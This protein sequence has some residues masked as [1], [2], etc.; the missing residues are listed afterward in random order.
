MIHL[1]RVWN[2][3]AARIRRAGQIALLFDFD[4][5]L[6][7][8]ASRPDLPR[9][10]SSNRKMLQ[11][12]AQTNRVAVGVVSGRGLRDLRGRVQL[13]GIYYAGNHGLELEGPR[14]RFLH[15]GAAAARADL[16]RI[17]RELRRRLKGVSG[18][19]VEDKTLSLSLHLRR[20]SRARRAHV[21]GLFART[22][23]PYLKRGAIRVTRGKLVVEVRPAVNWD[24]GSAVKLIRRQ[25]QRDWSSRNILLCYLGDDETDEAAFRA[26]GVHDFAIFVGGRKRTSA[27]VYY[28]RDPGEVEDFLTRVRSL[29]K[30]R[31]A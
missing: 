6:S 27:A 7:P 14:V 22:V 5:T 20:V 3:C 11:A 17:A 29:R 30:S 18:V 10:S 9:L 24:K 19:L 26:L 21:R 13:R 12:L 2:R 15:P 4:G 25:I 23:K 28:L 16:V 8:I 1:F 31:A